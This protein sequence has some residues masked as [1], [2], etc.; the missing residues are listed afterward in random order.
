MKEV[1]KQTDVGERSAV[2][3]ATKT[4]ERLNGGG[5]QAS[6]RNGTKGSRNKGGSRGS[7]RDGSRSRA[8]AG[9]INN[10][11]RGG[12]LT[13]VKVMASGPKKRLQR[14]LR[15]QKAGL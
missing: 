7:G 10:R 5:T 13:S 2:K 15:A 6:A 3:T 1:R 11:G 4:T 14:V 9:Q 12:N 8:D